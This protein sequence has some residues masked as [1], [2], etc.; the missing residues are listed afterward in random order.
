MQT[1]A[2]ESLLVLVLHH[3]VAD[4][5]SIGVIMADLMAAYNQA[6]ANPGASPI[7]AVQ[8]CDLPLQYT[9]YSAWIHAALR[10]G[11]LTPKVRYWEEQLKGTCLPKLPADAD[12]AHDGPRGT[13][14]VS[15][16]MSAEV[17]DMLE[18]L[19]INMGTST[20]AVIMAAYQVSSFYAMGA[21]PDT[22]CAASPYTD[23]EHCSRL[24]RRYHACCNDSHCHYDCST[25][26]LLGMFWA[27]RCL[28]QCNHPT[29]AP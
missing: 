1:S 11:V 5:W 25:Q 15:V 3:M 29:K 19:A 22:K 12:V 8:P 17:T 13:R 10:S 26:G 9:A 27:P 16:Q 21:I 28:V 4:G 18:E 23:A 20:F 24:G 2:H 14:L 6:V 7:D